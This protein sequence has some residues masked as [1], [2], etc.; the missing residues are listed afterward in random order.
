MTECKSITYWEKSTLFI[1][2]RFFSRGKDIAENLHQA[3]QVSHKIEPYVKIIYTQPQA[4]LF[5]ILTSSTRQE[6]SFK[7]SVYPRIL[8]LGVLLNNPL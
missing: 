2:M 7:C 6:S 3:P 4:S 8:K 5:A 1:L